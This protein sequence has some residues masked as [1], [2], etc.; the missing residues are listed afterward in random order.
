MALIRGLKGHCPCSV[1]LVKSEDLSTFN[2]S[3]TAR[4]TED[5]QAIVSSQLSFTAKSAELKPL[6]LR[7]VEVYFIL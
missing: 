6:G 1:C 5:G 3:Y 4:K 2:P 7:P